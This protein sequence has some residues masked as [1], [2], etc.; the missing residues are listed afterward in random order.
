ML[1]GLMVQNRH[2]QIKSHLQGMALPPLAKE[3][4]Q[5]AALAVRG[6]VTVER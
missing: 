1:A 3:L 5:A 4:T 2:E 6:A